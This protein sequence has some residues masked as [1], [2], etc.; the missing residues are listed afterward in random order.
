MC[1]IE[2]S[3]AVNRP[4]IQY[5][6]DLVKRE[7]AVFNFTEFSKCVDVFQYTNVALDITTNGVSN[8]VE[9][10]HTIFDS[11]FEFE[12]FVLNVYCVFAV[13][14]HVAYCSIDIIVSSA[15]A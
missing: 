2:Q 1:F 8:I 5:T 14:D 9:H 15:P 10:K 12:L 11:L 7:V 13:V 4:V 3:S 6:N